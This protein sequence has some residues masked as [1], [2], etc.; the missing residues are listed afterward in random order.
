[1]TDI[2]EVMRNIGA[3]IVVALAT[4]VATVVG[5]AISA[6]LFWLLETLQ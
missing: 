5:V 3:L 2:G 6:T 1:M 4:S